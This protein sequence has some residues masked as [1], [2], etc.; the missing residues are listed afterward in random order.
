LVTRE[1]VSVACTEAVHDDETT[2]EARTFVFVVDAGAPRR[3]SIADVVGESK[4]PA[5]AV[6][7]AAQ[8][9]EQTAKPGAPG[10]ADLVDHH[11]LDRFS[12]QRTG[13]VFELPP[14][15]V[16]LVHDELFAQIDW[17]TLRALA[18]EASI[19]DRLQKAAES[20]EAIFGYTP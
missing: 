3:L 16:S 17:S 6:P 9:A 12:A 5:L 15:V 11:A 14:G 19:V 7:I 18:L 2:I 1:V 4:L 13:L 20:P 8:L 10:P